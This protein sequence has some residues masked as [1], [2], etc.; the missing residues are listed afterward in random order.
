MKQCELGLT[1]CW[2]WPASRTEALQYHFDDVG[3]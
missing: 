2:D 3:L 1:S